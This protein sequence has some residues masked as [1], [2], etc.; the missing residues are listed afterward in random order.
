MAWQAR[1]SNG[2]PWLRHCEFEPAMTVVGL[3]FSSHPSS[4]FELAMTPRGAARER[5]ESP[6]LDGDKHRRGRFWC[7]WKTL[8][9]QS[10]M[11]SH[12]QSRWLN[13][14]L[15]PFESDSKKAPIHRIK[16]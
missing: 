11:N 6:E 12:R 3:L 15:V 10:L 4:G 7:N 14:E 1:R 9:R 2:A 8:E 13:N 5:R 16:R